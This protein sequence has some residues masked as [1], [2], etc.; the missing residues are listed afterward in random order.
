MMPITI[1]RVDVSLN[2]EL[3]VMLAFMCLLWSMG[4][5]NTIIYLCT[6]RLGPN[7]WSRRHLSLSRS[8]SRTTRKEP[9]LATAVRIHVEQSTQHAID[10]ESVPV[11]R[12]HGLA[13]ILTNGDISLSDSTP[14]TPV[15]KV[16]F[17]FGGLPHHVPRSRPTSAQTAFSPPPTPTTPQ[18][19]KFEEP[20]PYAQARSPQAYEP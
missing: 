9:G 1:T 13:S 17:E 20:H 11:P 19:L 3:S 7:P 14:T 12:E 16:G 2:V 10:E 6:R 4:T 15:H 8:R 18:R 5:A